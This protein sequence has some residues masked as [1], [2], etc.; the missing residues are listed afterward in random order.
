MTSF[1]NLRITLYGESHGDCVG[2]VVEGLAPGIPFTDEL[3]SE[4]LFNHYLGLGKSSRREL[5]FVVKSGVHQGVTTGAALCLE[6]PNLDPQSATYAALAGA[7]R[8]NHADYTQ[9][10]RSA[11]A[12]DLRGGGVSSGRAYV[13]LEITGHVLEQYLAERGIRI[14]VHLQQFAEIEDLPAPDVS[15]LTRENFYL[16]SSSAVAA[17]K[18]LLAGAP[19]DAFG[20]IIGVEVRGLPAGLGGARLER[21][22]ASLAQLIFSIPGIKALEFGLGFDFATAPSS[23]LQEVLCYEDGKPVFETNYG[24][25]LAGGITTGAPLTFRVAVKPTP[26]I[27]RPLSTINVLTKE[28]VTVRL[29]GRHDQ[30]IVFKMFDLLKAATALV[31]YDCLGGDE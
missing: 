28:N 10:V 2:I 17:V 7:V 26:T 15:R 3:I 12:A 30:A 16:A 22:E 8:P 5:A 27:T 14:F 13:P 23:A 11:G 6:L 18:A 20:G 4:A 31:I 25:G 24:G 21:L 29:T 9:F 19:D 1:K